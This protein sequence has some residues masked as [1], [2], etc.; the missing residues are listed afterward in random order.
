[1]H[2][3]NKNT[4]ANKIK[5]VRTHIAH[6]TQKEFAEAL[7]VTRIYINQLENPNSPKSPSDA[8]LRRI[9]DLYE[10]D[11]TYLTSETST[12]PTPEMSLLMDKIYLDTLFHAEDESST[13]L[14]LVAQNYYRLICSEMQNS[15]SSK[16]MDIKSYE[17]YLQVFLLFY[18][19]L[20]ETSMLLKTQQSLPNGELS[21]ILENYLK[22]V[23]KQ[24]NILLQKG[25][26][27]K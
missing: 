16:S 6:A 9:S 10:I 13:S 26:K 19:P 11:Y 3:Q 18:E 5:R 15:L 1:M 17:N 14:Q 27:Q 4:L 23:K 25:E 2:Q 22:T 7:G 24:V 8:L 12:T 21:N 20:M